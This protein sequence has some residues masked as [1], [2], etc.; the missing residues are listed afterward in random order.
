M[1][2]NISKNFLVFFAMLL[3]GM[4]NHSYAEINQEYFDE[5]EKMKAY[6]S[7]EKLSVS[8]S[9]KVYTQ[10][11]NVLLDDKTGNYEKSGS[12][13]K[14]TLGQ[15]TILQDDKWNLY[16]NAEEKLMAVKEK[17]EKSMS[18]IM[19]FDEATLGCETLSRHEKDGN[20]VY[21]LTFK[22]PVSKVYSN[23]ELIAAKS[24]LKPKKI[25]FYYAQSTTQTDADGTLYNDKLRFEITY[26]E[27]DNKV[28][29][30][31]STSGYLKEQGDKL[32]PSSKYSDYQLIDQR[33]SNLK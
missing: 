27:L 13:Y 8:I 19:S 22:S 6:F 25:I 15:V 28:Q 5:I 18:A 32:T 2:M 12:S 14:Y 10:T 29:E 20:L 26:L 16:I 33:T 21:T 4:K 3:V 9:Y 11:G 30:S 17:D 23:V 1:K 24:S 7:A 31:F